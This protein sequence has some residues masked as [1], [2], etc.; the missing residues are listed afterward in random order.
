MTAVMDRTGVKGA[1]SGWVVPF[2]RPDLG[3][4]EIAAVAR[5]L[6]S[7]WLTNGPMVA[8]FEADFARFLGPGVHAVA[9]SANTTGLEIALQALGLGPG[10]EVIT[11]VNTFIATALAIAHVG[12]MP[13]LAD[14]DPATLM[15]DPAAVE[16]AI[17]SATRAILP[18]HIAGLAC[19]LGALDAIA[20]RHGLK[21]V[22][23]A[24][25]AFP[26]RWRT[27]MIGNGTSDATVFSFYA[28]KTITTGE[29]GMVTTRDPELARRLRL[30]RLHGIDKDA[31][32]RDR[33]TARP[34]AYDVVEAGRKANMPDI[35]AAIGIEQ[36]KKAAA[37]HERRSAI[38]RRYDEAFAGLPLVLPAQ[39]APG[40]RHAWHLY[41]VRLT[42]QAGIDRDTF[43]ARLAEQ[44]IQCSVHF[45]PLHRHTYWRRRPDAD[46]GRFPHAEA[47]FECSATLP[48]FSA[49]S[50]AEVDLVI[51]AVRR[52]LA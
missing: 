32:A 44:G 46:R 42:R 28:S 31:F 22:E 47:A 2:A 5:C 45:I 9:T 14:I 50:D 43:I 6:R 23:D 18:V 1:A 30:L 39:P 8:R 15:I 19:D 27:R 35:A 12:A 41:I 29:G 51:A 7:G 24:A 34:W 40:G 52:L 20:R 13:V 36:L 16:A 49:M 26:A 21:V 25:H 11:S 17:T 10:D 48:L 38:A 3:E 33:E 4:E 37:F